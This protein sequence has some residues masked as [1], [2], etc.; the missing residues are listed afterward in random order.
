MKKAKIPYMLLSLLISTSLWIYFVS[1]E[2]PQKEEMISGI[3]VTF[4]GEQELYEDRKLIVTGGNKKTVSLVVRGNLIDIANLKSRKDEIVV[5]VDLSRISRSG[6]LKLPYT[7]IL[8]VYNVTLL[9]RL[10]STIDLK[11]EE[12][13]TAAIEIVCRNEGSIAEGFLGGEPIVEP[14]TLQVS[15]SKEIVDRI[16]YAEVVWTRENISRTLQAELEFNLIDKNGDIIPSTGLV[17]NYEFIRVTMPVQKTREVNLQVQLMPG[18]GAVESNIAYEIKPGVI[19]VA[20][21]VDTIDALNT[22]IVGTIDLAKILSPGKIEFPIILPNEV[23]SLSGETTAT[24]SITQ[25]SGLAI[26]GFV[27]NNLSVINAPEGMA[28]SILTTE[29]A[30][31]LRG[32]REDIGLL[33]DHNLRVVADM[34]G[35]SV[36]EGKYSVT[37]NVYVDGFPSVGVVG[38]Y[39]VII[40]VTKIGEKP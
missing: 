40:Q 4:E 31:N 12:V 21:D 39:K 15:G 37:A 28:V 36:S 33:Y 11:V 35:A 23:V 26:E 8:P 30:V 1:I 10:P 38:E 7:V 34:N 24:V 5:G 32:P 18:G 17:T 6:N 29:L 14:T 27:C 16:A 2:K 19:T 13:E 25:I 3:K 20:G 9:E 22:M